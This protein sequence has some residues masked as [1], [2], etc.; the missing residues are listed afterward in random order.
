MKIIVEKSNYKLFDIGEND[1]VLAITNNQLPD[2]NI[3]LHFDL[4]KDVATTVGYGF[5]SEEKMLQEFDKITLKKVSNTVIG[6]RK[7]F[8]GA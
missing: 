2:I 5:K 6:I 3:E 8:N 7:Q 1:Y 4:V